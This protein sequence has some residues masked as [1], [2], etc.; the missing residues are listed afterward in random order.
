MDTEAKNEADF[1]SSKLGT[2]EYWDDAYA[3]ELQAFEDIGDVGE[4]WF[5]EDVQDR[6]VRWLTRKEVDTS[7]HMLDLGTGNGM[8][9]LALREEGF[10][11]LVGVDYS[12]GAVQ[13]ARSVAQKEGMGDI[14]FQVC[15]ILSESSVCQLCKS[16][17]T[18]TLSGGGEPDRKF[19]VCLDKGTYDA[20]SLQRPEV[21]ADRDRYR[22]NVRSLLEPGGLLMLTSCNWTKDQLVTH[23][24]KDFELVEELPAPKFTFGGQTGQTVTSLVFR[25]R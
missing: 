4:I 14:Q 10:T 20:V 22:T 11:N 5:G 9:L 15:D 6:M 12:E 2:K 19:S 7:S 13:L 23:F 3:R 18:S 8:L 1:E 25:S 16:A 21:T 24:H 17:T